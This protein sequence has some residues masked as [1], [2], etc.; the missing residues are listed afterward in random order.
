MMATFIDDCV[1][2][3]SSLDVV[4]SFKSMDSR[5]VII[6]SNYFIDAI[7]SQLSINVVFIVG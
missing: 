1:V 7:T 4:V 2:R 3:S 5:I 6:E